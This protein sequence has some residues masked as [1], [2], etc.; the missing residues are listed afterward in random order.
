[1]AGVGFTV[2]RKSSGAP[3][4]PFKIGVTII[5]AICVV[6]TLAVVKFRF[7]V[8]DAA[9]PIVVFEFVQL[10]VAPAVPE[11]GTLNPV[12]PQ[13][14][15][16]E[17]GFT[18]GVG[19]TVMVML[20]VLEQAIGSVTITVYIPASIFETLENVMVC[21][22]ELKLLGPLQAKL[23]LGKGVVAV[24]ESVLPSQGVALG[25]SAVMPAAAH[26]PKV[27]AWEMENVPV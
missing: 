2:I 10:Y 6:V 20:L 26:S 14:V 18:A 25:G 23:G 3:M 15:L 27:R 1:M 11:N 9:S 19:F 24:K 4:Q 12:P 17:V 21:W 8:P 16:S 5:V 13:A 7:P 22:V